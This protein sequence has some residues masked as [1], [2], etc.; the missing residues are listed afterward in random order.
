MV[1]IL[2][3]ARECGDYDEWNDDRKEMV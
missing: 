3:V 1:E 2:E